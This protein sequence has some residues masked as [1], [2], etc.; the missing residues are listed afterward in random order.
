MKNKTVPKFTSIFATLYFIFIPSTSAFC[1]DGQIYGPPSS[2]D[3]ATRATPP[4]DISSK[5]LDETERKLV[6]TRRLVN[7]LEIGYQLLNA[8]DAAQTISC[9][10]KPNC[11]E[12]NPLYGKRPSVG[13]IIGIKAA[14]ALLHY[15]ASR[16][17]LRRD[18]NTAILFEVATTTVQGVVCGLNFRYAF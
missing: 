3:K 7:N 6:R 9:V 4:A 16:T 10:H 13:T 17:L 12:G 14:S 8:L 5:E 11:E 15:R 2:E 18:P 1:H